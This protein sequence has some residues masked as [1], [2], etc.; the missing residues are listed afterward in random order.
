M[1][2][3]IL[4]NLLAKLKKEKG[5]NRFFDS[6]SDHEF[7]RVIRELNIYD[8]KIEFFKSKGFK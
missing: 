4:V 1:S 2:K 5:E 7:K 6:N 3:M 8:K